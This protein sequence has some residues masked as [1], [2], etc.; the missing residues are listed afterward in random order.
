MRRTE[1]RVISAALALAA[2]DIIDNE[3]TTRLMMLEAS[4]RITE[5]VETLQQYAKYSSE[6]AMER[7]IRLLGGGE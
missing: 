1:T 4:E 2:N 5:L 7:D 6:A 3:G